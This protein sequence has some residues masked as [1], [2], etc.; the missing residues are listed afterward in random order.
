MR[1]WAV[2]GP[3]ALTPQPRAVNQLAGCSSS[4]V[5]VPNVRTSWCTVAPGASRTQAPTSYSWT[6][7]PAT[8]IQHVHASRLRA[9]A[10]PQGLK[11]SRRAHQSK[12]VANSRG[13]ARD[14]VEGSD[15]RLGAFARSRG[16]RS[17]RLERVCTNAGDDRRRRLNLILRLKDVTPPPSNTRDWPGCSMHSVER[18]LADRCRRAKGRPATR[19]SLPNAGERRVVGPPGFEPGTNRL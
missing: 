16:A 17:G 9:R 15:W 5:A 13:C 10:N 1:F 19:S 2:P 3:L 6:W 8:G 11:F 18:A 7:S 4:S 14:A 12:P